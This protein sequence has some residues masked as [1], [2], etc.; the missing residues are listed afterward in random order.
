M[1]VVH[2]LNKVYIVGPLIA[3]VRLSV[4]LGVS[5]VPRCFHLNPL[6]WVNGFSAQLRWWLSSRHWYYVELLLLVL[7]VLSKKASAKW[8]T[9]VRIKVTSKMNIMKSVILDLMTT[10]VIY[11]TIKS[12]MYG[13]LLPKRMHIMSG[14]KFNSR[15]MMG[16]SRFMKL[17]GK[18]LTHVSMISRWTDFNNQTLYT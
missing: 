18:D 6:P 2:T 4:F 10:M 11:F 12:V 17:F 15:R 16:I 5:T 13:I 1:Q 9:R 8:G 3:S 7:V 14:L